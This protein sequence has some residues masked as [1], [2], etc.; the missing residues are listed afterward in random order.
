MKMKIRGVLAALVVLASAISAAFTPAALDGKFATPVYFHGV[1]NGSSDVT[2][3][4]YR[5]ST[6]TMIAGSRTNS[7][8]GY[9]P[10][11]QA[12][13]SISTWDRPTNV[14]GDGFVFNLSGVNV[15]TSAAA[16]IG[17]STNE[18]I[19]LYWSG[20]TPGGTNV[21]RYSL[22]GV[23]K[24]GN[25]FSAST[26]NVAGFNGFGCQSEM[27]EPMNQHAVLLTT[28]YR[29]GKVE[30]WAT[31]RSMRPRL[32]CQLT[33]TFTGTDGP[34]PVTWG[35][36]RLSS[37]NSS[38]EIEMPIVLPDRSMSENEIAQLADGISPENLGSGGSAQA[39]IRFTTVTDGGTSAADTFVPTPP[40]DG[41]TITLNGQVFT[42]RNSPSLSTDVQIVPN[43]IATSV[44]VATNTITLANHGIPNGR[45]LSITRATTQPT[46]I[47]ADSGI[48]VVNATQNTFQ[49]ALTPGGTPI[50]NGTNG[51]GTIT[52]GGAAATLD[53]LA[54][55]LD[56]LTPN[57]GGASNASYATAGADAIY[58]TSRTAGGT[59]FTFSTTATVKT[60][61]NQRLALAWVPITDYSGYRDGLY[62]A[63]GLIRNRGSPWVTPTLG[64]LA[65]NTQ[66]TGSMRVVSWGDGMVVQHKNGFGNLALSGIYTGV[67]PSGV[68]IYVGDISDHSQVLPF[69][70]CTSFTVDTSAKTWTAKL[71]GSLPKAKRWNELQTRK[72]GSAQVTQL[73]E[74]KFGVGELIAMT[75]DSIQALMTQRSGAITPNQFISRFVG[76]GTVLGSTSGFWPVDNT[77]H[78]F[79]TVAQTGSGEGALA[80]TISNDTNAVVG[81]DNRAVGGSSMAVLAT[82]TTAASFLADLSNSFTDTSL[83]PIAGTFIYDEANAD[84]GSG[85]FAKLDNFYPNWL[86]FYFGSEIRLLLPTGINHQNASIDF[87]YGTW[88]VRTDQILWLASR[89][90]DALVVDAGDTE[91]WSSGGDGVHP[92]DATDFT[93]KG[94]QD[95]LSLEKAMG[96]ASF[97]GVGP[98][99]ISATRSGANIDISF[100]LNGATG[101][102]TPAAGDVTGFDF[103]LTSTNFAAIFSNVTADPATDKI[104]WTGHGL[105]NGDP[106]IITAVTTQPG[107]TTAGT[108]VFVI[109][110]TANDFQ[111]AA[112]VGGS[113]IDITSAGSGV[114]ATSTKNLLPVTSVSILNPTTVRAVLASAP[115]ASVSVNVMWGFP[116]RKTTDPNPAL[117]P[118]SVTAMTTTTAQG[119]ILTDNFPLNFSN[120]HVPG[121]PVR[122][123]TTP[124]VTNW[125]LKRDLDPAAN[126]NSPMW[127]AKAS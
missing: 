96:V 52:I 125:L 41:Q 12:E 36:G 60:P 74:V 88:L 50:S 86:R 47:E 110:A 113:V 111:T 99:P 93:F 104:L 98:I 17:G 61:T 118:N 32:L 49:T 24:A 64:E 18:A 10:Q 72:S 16:T 69:T 105:S 66:V 4:P 106:V 35:G 71:S 76:T 68:Q 58:I 107:G 48:Y 83:G 14:T 51:S 37:S 108:T 46:G 90:G 9:I 15:N 119:N 13:W 25:K 3:S 55:V 7:A 91:F 103:S 23:D 122:G 101:L 116:G 115:G 56:A 39:A 78:R 34:L 82:P 120:S 112:T 121:R 27:L 30:L 33:A 114:V 126:D 81:L 100:S 43:L 80:N 67:A 2:P 63:P 6:Q 21:N 20:S 22:T 97:S 28:Q 95:A 29:A 44:D 102:Q 65:P 127:L 109:N 38:L 75:G 62:A 57:T 19:A 94:G 8:P 5:S 84:S 77:W 53:N 1:A 54:T 45:R 124:L 40:T 123:T 87:V 26:V 31:Y 85:F 92:S 79:Q 11:L 117:D 59:S 42:F 73:S 89:A 70:T